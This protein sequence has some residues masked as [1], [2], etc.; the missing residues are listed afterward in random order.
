MKLSQGQ[1]LIVMFFGCV[2]AYT[3][4]VPVWQP[5]PAHKAWANYD[6]DELSSTWWEPPKYY[7]SHSNEYEMQIDWKHTAIR[8]LVVV[9]GFVAAMI[10]SEVIGKRRGLGRG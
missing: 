5:P 7:D 1:W 10:A 9:I 4:F 8:N 6:G 3:V 2:L